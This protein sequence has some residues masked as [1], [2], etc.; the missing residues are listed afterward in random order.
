[1]DTRRILTMANPEITQILSRLRETVSPDDTRQLFA[2]VYEE[3]RSAADRLMNRERPEHT[4][5]ATALVHEAYLKLV[6]SNTPRWEDRAHFFGSASRAMRQ[7]LVDHA[8]ARST[9]KRGGDW[10][11]VTLSEELVSAEESVD[12]L[13]LDEAL[14]ELEKLD[15]RAAKVAELRLIAGLTVAEIAETLEVSKRTVNGDWTMARM[16]LA[17]TLGPPQN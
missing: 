12:I 4:L 6:G 16:W 9:D 15:S 14:T 10:A 17:R 1:M 3:L 2:L 7:I 5:Q 8:R 13:A 11:R